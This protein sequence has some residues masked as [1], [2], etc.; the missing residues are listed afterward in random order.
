MRCR[1]TRHRS[2]V[3]TP[4]VSSP[5]IINGFEPV[6]TNG[7]DENGCECS[8]VQDRRM[9]L[10]GRSYLGWIASEYGVDQDQSIMAD[11]L[12]MS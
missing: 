9:G 7:R 4:V 5:A 2:P 12:E 6:A 1:D 8:R 10:W 11:G 3:F